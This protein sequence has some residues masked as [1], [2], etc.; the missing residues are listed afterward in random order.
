MNYPRKHNGSVIICG[1][2]RTLPRDYDRAKILRPSAKVIAVNG[3]SGQVPCFALFTQ[4]PRKLPRWIEWQ[5]ARFNTDFTVHAAGNNERR[6]KMNLTLRHDYV[7]YWWKDVASGGTSAW[8]ARRMAHFMGFDEVILCGVPLVPMQYANNEP[9]KLMLRTEVMEHYRQ[10]IMQDTEFHKGVYSM[11][12]WTREYF[13][14]PC[15]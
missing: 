1:N 13:G 5:K 8:G 2:A 7:D 9:A 12:G 14:E 11:S 3:A 15:I 10:Q 4:H 6:T